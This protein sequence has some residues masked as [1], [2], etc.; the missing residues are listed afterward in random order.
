MTLAEVARATG[1][2]LVGSDVAVDGVTI[3][4]R[5]VRPGQLFVP[6]VAARDGHEFVPAALAAGAAAHLTS[7]P[8]TDRAAG[9]AVVVPD[10][11]AALSRL[12]A[13]ARDRLAATVVGV[14]GSVGK[15]SVKDLVAGAVGAARATWASAK[16]FN[17]ELGVPLTLVEAPD[18]TEVVVLE[19]GMRGF[20][21]LRALCALAR[22]TVGVVTALA[23][24]HT[25]MVGG[26]E[27]V[28][29]AKGELIEALPRHGT[30][31][32]NADQG[33]VAAMARRTEATVVSFGVTRGDVRAEL[34]ELDAELRP[35][36]RLHTPEGRVELRLGVRGAHQA[37]NAAAAAAV[38]TVVGVALAEA[39]EGLAAVVPSA[40]R[41]EVH[42]TPAGAVVVNDAYNA[43]PTSTE[44]ALRAL[45]ALP[46]RRRVAVLGVMAELGAESDALHREVAAVAHE[47]GIELVAVGTAGYGPA[48]VPGWEEA[49]AVLGDLGAGDAVL[50]K[51][52]RVAGLERLAAA[53][54]ER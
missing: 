23:P 36:V 19:M 22:P 12:G 46:A 2:E 24:A 16:S 35:R 31:V 4:S 43:N 28:A 48:P 5:A 10:T 53:L 50:V 49:R 52:S 11:F 44:A 6:I 9:P 42:R 15:T 27:G 3:D 47:L 14:T 8:P 26:L 40:W 39:A 37:A 18:A 25:E 41:M 1:G 32:L 33:A 17:N 45:A 7:R 13:H 34:L 38:A 30:A 20:G 21:H 54:L 29:R 51:G